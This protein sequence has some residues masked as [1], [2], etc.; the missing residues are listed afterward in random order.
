MEDKKQS[1]E[2]TGIVLER[3]GTKGLYGMKLALGVALPFGMALVI[4][5]H[6][7][8]PFEYDNNSS[9]TLSQQYEAEKD[10]DIPDEYE[11]L[12]NS[13]SA[14]EKASDDYEAIQ[15]IDD[16]D[17]SIEL[18]TRQ[19]LV[20]SSDILVDASMAIIKG[21]IKESLGLSDDAIIE[22]KSAF[23]SADGVNHTIIITDG[24]ESYTIDGSKLPSEYRKQLDRLYEESRY[25][26]N[27]TGPKWEQQ[28][29]AYAE[30]LDG[31]YYG[32]LA[33][34]GDEAPNMRK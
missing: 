28:I 7:A 25:Q 32:A 15:G 5:N 17:P 13:L 11:E 1:K 12:I 6:G 23:N 16:I 21:K 20:D 30:E 9:K 27:G 22:I 14:Y 31:I 3:V 24:N 2:I 8:K 10:V 18:E 33:M 19:N 26:G 4:A 34:S 29:A